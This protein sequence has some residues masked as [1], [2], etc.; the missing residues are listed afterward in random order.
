M[1]PPSFA[2]DTSQFGAPAG[3]LISSS[4]IILFVKP[5]VYC[6]YSAPALSAPNIYLLSYDVAFPFASYVICVS[7]FIKRGFRYA[8]LY[9]VV[10]VPSDIAS[11]PAVNT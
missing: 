11:V 7:L 6:K 5:T 9:V 2:Y 3:I 8:V 1:I 10:V 4:N